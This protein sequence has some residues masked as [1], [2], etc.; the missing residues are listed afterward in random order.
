MVSVAGTSSTMCT[1]SLSAL[2]TGTDDALSGSK[3]SGDDVCGGRKRPSPSR[4]LLACSAQK[5]GD[6]RKPGDVVRR[7]ALAGTGIHAC[8]QYGGGAGS[9]RMETVRFQP[10]FRSVWSPGLGVI[11]PHATCGGCRAHIIRA[12]CL[13]LAGIGGVYG[14]RKDKSCKDECE[15][16]EWRTLEGHQNTPLAP[17]PDDITP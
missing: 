6:A 10:G 7:A 12:G 13:W 2:R 8:T 16:F 1:R 9:T 14:E 15:R 3:S 17:A 11:Q 4:T 5:V